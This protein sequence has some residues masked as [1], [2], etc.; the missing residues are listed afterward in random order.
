MG[1]ATPV[2]G[3]FVCALCGEFVYEPPLAA[4]VDDCELT[5]SHEGIPDEYAERTRDGWGMI[6]DGI[7]RAVA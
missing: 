1:G 5:L 4:P 2:A 3:R 6:L 7:T